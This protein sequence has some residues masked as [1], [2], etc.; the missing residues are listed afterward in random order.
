MTKRSSDIVLSYT[1]DTRW[2]M[3][4]GGRTADRGR[5]DIER[6]RTAGFVI[7]MKKGF[8]I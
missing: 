6:D 2:R 7:L 1:P 4:D 5:L 3:G 8:L